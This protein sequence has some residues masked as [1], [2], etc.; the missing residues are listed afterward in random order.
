MVYRLRSYFA[1]M[2]SFF[3]GSSSGL[4]PLISYLNQAILIRS[5]DDFE[6]VE[7]SFSQY[8]K[9][10]WYFLLNTGRSRKQSLWLTCF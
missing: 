4:D 7:I 5:K 9:G 8:G 2:E 10:G 6:R 1:L 3:H